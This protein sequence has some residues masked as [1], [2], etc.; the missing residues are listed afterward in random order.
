MIG[1]VWQQSV[2]QPAAVPDR[3]RERRRCRWSSTA[4][5]SRAREA[6]ARDLLDQVGLADRRRPPPGRAVR[7]RAAA[8][9]DR[10]RAGQPARG[11]PRRRADRRARHGDRAPDL[12]PVPAP[13]PR[14]GRDDRRRH[15]R[16][17]RQRAGQPDG[18]DPRRPGEQRGAAPA[19]RL[20]R[21]RAPRHRRPSTRSST[22]SAGCSCRG[23]TS[24]RSGSSGGSGSSSRTTTSASG[25]T[26][27]APTPAGL[28]AGPIA[29]GVA[30]ATPRQPSTRSPALGTRRD[31]AMTADG[32]PL[33]PRHASRRLRT[34][35]W[36]RRT[37]CAATSP[38]AS[39]SST[40]SATWTCASS[41]ASWS[42]SAAA[43][44]R[45]R[46]RCCR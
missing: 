30:T 10:G 4:S 17:A 14:A 7:R 43:P 2:A 29:A 3:A 26:A 42:R 39:T 11:A 13:Q 5:A 24:R 23:R 40:P 27:Q 9:G 41:A 21:R 38:A 25:R 1:F 16:P 6:A 45:A 32:G 15:P 22:G 36:S 34:V 37:A 35:R 19:D 31:R 12:R 44:G 33:R 20:G 28:A 18:R 8:G 46:R